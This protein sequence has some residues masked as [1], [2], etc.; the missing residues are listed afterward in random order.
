[1]SPDTSKIREVLLRTRCTLEQF[2]V[3]G[4][5]DPIARLIGAQEGDLIEIVR[6]VDVG[7]MYETT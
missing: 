7:T 4:P 3:I 2:P 6:V 5:N 1:M